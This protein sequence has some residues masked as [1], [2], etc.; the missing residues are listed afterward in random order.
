M[1][2]EHPAHTAETPSNVDLSRFELESRAEIAQVL[3][4]LEREAA[5]VTAYFNQGN[6]F[7]LTTVVEVNPAAG[8]VILDRGPDEEVNRRA[9]VAG[10]ILFVTAQDKVKVQ[11]SAPTLKETLYDGRTAF[12]IPF[13]ATLLKLQRRE[14]YRLA[15]PMGSPLVCTLPETPAGRLEVTVVD[16][17]VGGVGLSGFPLTMTLEIG[18]KLPAARIV[19]PHEGTLAS[20]L[21]VRNV[22]RITL[23]SGAQVQRAGC[24]FVDLPP[25]HQAMIQ[26][27]IT[28]VDR[29]R[30]ALLR[31]R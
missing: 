9:L 7:F 30:R 22:Q 28:R 21:E 17:S 15:T 19:L 2:P 29:E 11:F 10:K 4:A 18:Q 3:R 31:G 25:A 23:R 20:A 5:L 1:S 24:R 6:E 16:I 27:Y 14:F 26:R 12:A 13:P 8:R